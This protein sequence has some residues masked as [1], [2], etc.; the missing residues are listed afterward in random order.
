MKT[1]IN[2]FLLLLLFFAS[3]INPIEFKDGAVES[4]LVLHS[5]LTPDE[6]VTVLLTASRFFLDESYNYRKISNAEVV[7]F[8]DSIAIDTLQRKAHEG[9]Y[10]GERNFYVGDSTG[11]YYGKYIP[12]AGDNLTL[13][14]SA[15]GF[16]PIESE[17]TI[18]PPPDFISA[19]TAN[20]SARAYVRMWYDENDRNK[21]LYDTAIHYFSSFNISLS[22]N[23][24]PDKNEYYYVV[25][26]VKTE[27]EDASVGKQYRLSYE[28]NNIV[29]SSNS[30][31]IGMIGGGE[32]E[33]DYSIFTDEF[34]AGKNYNINI[35]YLDDGDYYG[36]N[37][38]TPKPFS[39]VTAQ[40]LVVEL[41]SVSKEYYLYRKSA[42]L[43][44]D[45]M[46]GRFSEPVQIYSN[47][48]GGIGIA[49]SYNVSR[50]M[51][52]LNSVPIINDG[53]PSVYYQ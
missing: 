39:F 24:T 33:K 40:Y 42:M 43:S 18:I 23:D 30:V 53:Y 9:V 49:G 20:M 25:L 34:F 13:R 27:Y 3:C 31:T 46:G 26:Y 7:L 37:Y 52:K 29:F 36:N 35:Y 51:F 6:G 22:F 21:I 12:Q 47:V 10:Y 45:E 44:D 2:I 19:D 32:A 41:H 1:K 4:K 8:K 16:E 14:A 5:L 48:K 28:S 50:K 15:Q 38:W 11:I 17:L